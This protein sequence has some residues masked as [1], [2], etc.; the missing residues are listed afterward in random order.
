MRRNRPAFTLIELLVVIAII[1]VLIALL[2]PAVQAA[3]EAARR[4]QCVNNLKQ[5]GLALH[6]YHDINGV[7]PPNRY[8]G[9]AGGP[10]WSAISQM[11]PQ[12]EQ[13]QLFAALNFNLPTTDPSNLTGQGTAVKVFLCPSDG[14]SAYPAGM[15][16]TNYRASEGANFYYKYGA[17][18]PT[19]SNAGMPAP[20]GPFYA[21]AS[22]RIADITDGT[23]NTAAF[24]EM[25]IGDQNQAIATESRDIFQPG[26]NPTTLDQSVATCQG[27]A[28]TNLAL[29]GWS[30]S[31]TPWVAGSAACSVYK[32]VAPPNKR[33]C[34]YPPTRYITTA[35][36]LHPGG[37][38]VGMC[39][40]SVRFI[41][42]TINVTTWR[43]L[44]SRNWGEIISSDSL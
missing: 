23:S 35:R 8:T 7:L 3:R 24:G 40:G 19:G 27:I 17:D 6:N 15:A 38:N 9:P 18:D 20:D 43:A 1:A 32:H 30:N 10:T 26:T 12:V 28:I 16:G 33:S 5:L 21:D 11:L 39:D 22:F 2:L 13:A 31:G 4:S 14:S 29:Q 25:L 36:S 37:V 34:M 44:G 41:K 42:D